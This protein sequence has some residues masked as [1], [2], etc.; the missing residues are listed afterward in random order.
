MA[1]GILVKNKHSQTKVCL[2]LSTKFLFLKM[3]RSTPSRCALLFKN[4]SLVLNC[5]H[6]L[7]TLSEHNS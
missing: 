7:K 4:K 2:Q 6:V 1:Y 3:A 5:K